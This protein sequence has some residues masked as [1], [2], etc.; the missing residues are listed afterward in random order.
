DPRS[1]R[2]RATQADEPHTERVMPRNWF[3]SSPC[4]SGGNRRPRCTLRVETLEVRALPSG[5]PIPIAPSD[6]FAHVTSDNVPGQDGFNYANSQV[7]PYVAVNPRDHNNIVSVWQQDRWDNGAARGFQG[8]VSLD[9]GKT[10][11]PI[12]IPG[13]SQVTGGTAPRATDPWLTFSPD[14]AL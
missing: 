7:E 11:T 8:G 10:W 13:I 2:R 12:V 1:H 14:G 4:R 3:R 5:T 9:G 6:L